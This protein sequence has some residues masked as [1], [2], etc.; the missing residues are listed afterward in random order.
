MKKMFLILMLVTA[1]GTYAQTFGASSITTEGS[2]NAAN[3]VYK[4]WLVLSNKTD[5]V[6]KFEQTQDGLGSAMDL[7]AKML[8]QNELDIDSPDIAKNVINDVTRD[9]SASF[10][11]S[12]MEGKSK[13]NEAWNLPEGSTLHLFISKDSFEVNVLKAF[14][15]KY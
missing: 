10:L 2:F 8:L 5:V 4:K 7:V 11:R 14:R 1:V 15:K 13:I 3:P 6:M 9:N 12:V